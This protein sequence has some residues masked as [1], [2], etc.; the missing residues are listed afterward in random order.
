MST[1][2]NEPIKEKVL[3]TYEQIVRSGWRK[4][5]QEGWLKGEQEGWRKGEQEGWRKGEQEGEEK[6]AIRVIKNLY[7][8]GFPVG[9]IAEVVEKSEA[10]VLEVLQKE[11][12]S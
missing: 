9:E 8:R 5:E 4:G 6:K 11:G 2:L 3:S 10:F 1:K 12:L 7:K